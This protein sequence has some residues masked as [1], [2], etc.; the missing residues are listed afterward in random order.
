MFSLRSARGRAILA[1]VVLI[2]LL[3][4]VATL[5]VWRVRDDQQRHH[6]LEQASNTALALEHAHAQFNRGGGRLAALVFSDDPT[7]ADDYH[8]AVAAVEQNLSQARASALAQGHADDV[9]ALDDLIERIG[10]FNEKANQAVPFLLEVDTETAVQLATTL[11]SEMSA[12]S[13]AIIADLDELAHKE[14]QELA[15]ATATADRAAET[16][17]WLLIGFSATALVVAV[18]AI[19]M[20][21][22]SVVR[23]LAAL[24]ASARA[25]TTG[26]PE[27]RAKVYGPEEVASLARDFNE[28]T[29]ALSAKTQEYIDTT[30]LTGDIIARLDKHGNWAFVNDAACRFYGKPREELLGVQLAD[31]LHPEDIEPTTQTIQEMIE[32]KQLVRDFVNRQLT[33]MGTRMV[34]WNAIPLFDEEGHYTGFQATG[35]DITERRRAEEKLRESESK[36]RTLLEN[37]PQ[38]IFSKDKNC[39]YV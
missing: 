4:G 29:D 39:V 28:M 14:Q 12:A 23:P 2:V 22:V 27:A 16:T 8:H 17:L 19:A 37:L 35:R 11:M 36:H 6:T 20:L 3:A 30:N 21:I 7:L 24:R 13:N 26:D 34:E 32:S 33:P 15:A 38:K 10:Q 5:A 25:I 31:Y 18:G 1:G 9:L